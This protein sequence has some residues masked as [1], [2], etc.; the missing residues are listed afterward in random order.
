MICIL[1]DLRVS[2]FSAMFHFWVN[3]CFN[4]KAMQ[5]ASKGEKIRF[6]RNI[7]KNIALSLPQGFDVVQID[8]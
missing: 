6:D 1:D 5:W 3:Y 8:I 4:S 7:E 2:L